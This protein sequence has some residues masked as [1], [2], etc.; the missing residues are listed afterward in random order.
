MSI[1]CHHLLFKWWALALPDS[2]ILGPKVAVAVISKWLD[3]NVDNDA[4][5]DYFSPSLPDLSI[6]QQEKYQH[7]HL[8]HQQTRKY[9]AMK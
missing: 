1:H 3:E 6:Q 4:T 2:I 7:K 9:L 8:S 5:F